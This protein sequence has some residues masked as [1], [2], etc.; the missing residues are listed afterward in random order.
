MQHLRQHALGVGAADEQGRRPDRFRI[1]LGKWR[2]LVP[3][4]ADQCHGVVAQQLFRRR[5]Q[6]RPGA[7]A[8]Q[9]VHEELQ[10]AVDIAG[11]DL[12]GRGGEPRGSGEGA[13]GFTAGS[14]VA[15]EL[16]AGF[17]QDQPAQQIGP[18]LGDAKRDMPAAGMPHQ[19]DRPGVQ[20]LDEADHVIDMLGDR[21][22]VANAV[23]M[24]GKKV[25]QRNRDHAVLPR[26]RSE[27]RRP[28]AEIAQRAMHADQRRSLADV[29]IGHVV[30]VDVECLHV[31]AGGGGAD[32]TESAVISGIPDA[33]IHTRDTGFLDYRQARRPDRLTVVFMDAS[34]SPGIR[35]DRNYFQA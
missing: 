4:L 3:D 30:A 2:A 29:E 5:R 28:D 26:Q 12:L 35:V 10:P 24:R 31:G 25:P 20:L 33:Q 1:R 22:G 19:V 27:H 17:G 32:R 34:N 23:P 7:R 13:P 21:I 8:F 16:A 11:R 15:V 9:R 6:P 14:S 18:S